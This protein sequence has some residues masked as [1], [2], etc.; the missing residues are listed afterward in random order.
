MFF[1]PSAETLQR[2]RERTRLAMQ[3]PKVMSC[4]HDLVNEVIKDESL[5]KKREPLQCSGNSSNYSATTYNNFV[6]LWACEVIPS[7]GEGVMLTM[8]N[9]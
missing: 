5:I 9:Q 8:E 1:E 2:I 7:N 4:K 6:T 3:D